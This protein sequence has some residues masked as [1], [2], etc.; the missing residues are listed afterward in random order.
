MRLESWFITSPDNSQQQLL[1]QDIETNLCV[2][3]SAVSG[4]INMAIYRANQTMND[5]FAIIEYKIALMKIKE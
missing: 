3:R 4:K 2:N 5:K 1:K